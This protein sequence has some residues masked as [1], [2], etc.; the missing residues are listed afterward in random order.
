MPQLSQ[1][2]INN[3]AQQIVNKVNPVQIYLFGSYVKGNASPASDIDFLVVED[4]PFNA[5]HSRLQ[6]IRNIKRALSS[7]RVPKDILL[8]SKD[9]VEKWKTSLNHIVARC[10][11]EGKMLYAR[12]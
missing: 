3:M 1:S 2:D 12:S 11:R 8:Y 9:E 7:Y 5:L 10:L 4:Q 6:E